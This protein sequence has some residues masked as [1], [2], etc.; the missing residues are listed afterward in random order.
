MIVIE[1]SQTPHVDARKNS[2]QH[3]VIGGSQGF[4]RLHN[5]IARG[6]VPA[7]GEN[8][9]IRD[10][11]QGASIDQRNKRRRIYNDVIE[12]APQL[13]DQI[14]HSVGKDKFTITRCALS[15]RRRQNR[16]TGRPIDEQRLLEMRPTSGD[17]NCTNTRLRA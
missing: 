17:F 2:A 13:F 16:K 1:E 9:T 14:A 7:D 3:L 11:S 12:V 5:D 4:Q 8:D 6:A 10:F 15:W